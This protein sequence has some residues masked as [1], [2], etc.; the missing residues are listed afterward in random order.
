[1]A[2]AAVMGACASQAAQVALSTAPAVPAAAIDSIQLS[3][4][5]GVLAHDTMEGRL[6]GSE[7]S[8]R[9]QRFLLRRFQEI[10]LAQFGGTYAHPFDF[11]RQGN[12]IRGINIVGHVRGTVHSDRYIVVTAHYD[13]L[14][15]RNGE[16]YNGADDNASGTAGLLAIAHHFARNAPRHGMIFVAFDAEEGGLR[17]AHAFVAEPPV[18][19]S[20][21]VLN[22]N[23]DMIGRNDADE[24]Y[25]A[26]THHYPHLLPFV[27]RVAR[28]A[29][30]KLI[31]GH[32]TPNPANPSDDW[33]RA[34][35][36]GAFHAA[37]IPFLYFGVEDHPD[38]H[39]PSDTVEGIQPG[40]HVRAVSTV[41]SALRLLD[42]ELN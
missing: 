4:D 2:A 41:L 6:V 1:M 28:A 38:Y 3:Y 22:V 25:V 33:T 5:I 26:G 27:Q 37:G 18:P 21:I 29:P 19:Q 31:P 14:G 30:V 17:G 39:R 36:H 24:L 9:A 8:A 35:D 11:E 20:A 23:M 10:G 15:I 13:H 16:I 32:D 7:G 40:F 34:S 42:S 12:Q